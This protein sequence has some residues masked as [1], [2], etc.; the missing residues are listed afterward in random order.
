MTNKKILLVEDNTENQ[1]F[2]KLM[3]ESMG[4]V[5]DIAHDGNTAIEKWSQNQYN[6]I[7]MD[8]QMPGMNGYETAQEIRRLEE[9][10]VSK[11]IYI[12]ALTASAFEEDR[13]RCMEAGM[14]DYLSKPVNFTVLE[15]KL[16]TLSE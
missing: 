12:I 3:L 6:V 16:N 7:L 9:E 13:Q 14:D 15:E 2:M 4:H 11:H 1:A 5:L 8:I 10:K